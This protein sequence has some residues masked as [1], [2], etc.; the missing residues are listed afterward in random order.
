MPG[1]VAARLAALCG[2]WPALVSIMPE[3][4]NAAR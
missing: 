4:A 1:D 2:L 3:L